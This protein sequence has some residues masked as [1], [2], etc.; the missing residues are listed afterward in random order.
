MGNIATCGEF[1][2]ETHSGLHTLACNPLLESDLIMC[3]V[4]PVFKKD[5]MSVYPQSYFSAVCS[6]SYVRTHFICV[7]SVYECC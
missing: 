1:E 2:N 7:W 5:V 3:D 4:A 6:C